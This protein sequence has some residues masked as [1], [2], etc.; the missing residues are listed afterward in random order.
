VAGSYI[1]PVWIAEGQAFY[2]LSKKIPPRGESVIYFL[3]GNGTPEG[4]TTPVDILKA[5]LG[6][7]V[8]SAIRDVPG[9][10]LRTHHRRSD[11][12]VHRACT[13]GYTEAIQALFEAGLEVENRDIISGSVEDMNFFVDQH[14]RRINEYRSFAADLQALLATEG[15]SATAPLREALLPLVQKIPEE[16]RV[17]AE[18]MKSAEHAAELTRRTLVLTE[19]KRPDNLKAYMEL[20]DA[21]RAMGGAQDYVLA[22]CHTVAR[23]I[24]QQAGHGS[25]A[26]PDSVELARKVRERCREVLRNADGYE[27]WADY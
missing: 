12:D 23:D 2:H 8:A 5:S 1:Y 3:E 25:V 6:R 26:N 14:V 16:C 17:Q 10:K 7:S 4:V 13:C 19:K 9:G 20:L 15:L 11:G 18:N 24:F 27:I 22:L 21:W